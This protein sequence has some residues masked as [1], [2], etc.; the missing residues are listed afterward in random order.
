[1][2][3]NTADIRR[4]LTEAFN[5]RELTAFCF[6]DFRDVYDEFAAGY[7]TWDMAGNVWEWVADWY[8]ETYYQNAPVQNP[9]G[10]RSGIYRAIRG[11]SWYGHTRNARAADRLWKR[12]DYVNY[13]V[14][15]RCA[16]SP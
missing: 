9:S 15:F 11:G 10:S 16:R 5:D 7:G 14:G 3:T 12:P 6:D 8:S 1:M 13:N 2:T 4:F